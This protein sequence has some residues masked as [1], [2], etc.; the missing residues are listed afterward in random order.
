MAPLIRKLSKMLGSPSSNAGGFRIRRGRRICRPF[1]WL[2]LAAAL[3]ACTAPGGVGVKPAGSPAAEGVTR[4]IEGGA[5]QWPSSFPSSGTPLLLEVFDSTDRKTYFANLNVPY[6]TFLNDLSVTPQT[7]RLDAN[8]TKFYTPS[9]SYQFNVTAA[10]PL[11]AG[12]RSEGNLASYGVLATAG[13]KGKA[14]DFNNTLNRVDATI[15]KIRVNISYINQVLGH[16]PAPASSAV[17]AGGLEQSWDVRGWDL[18]GQPQHL[19]LFANGR[20]SAENLDTDSRF[21]HVAFNP[22]RSDLPRWLGTFRLNT[23]DGA[24]LYI[25]SPR[26][27][28]SVGAGAIR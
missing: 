1:A 6:L 20:S 17:V 5:I 9:H 24:L 11:Y 2:G 19:S 13:Q 10:L 4:A 27:P 16:G 21:F 18:L 12:G 8:W 14:G 3:A 15:N 7:W 28:A 22:N 25:P 23:G 26:H